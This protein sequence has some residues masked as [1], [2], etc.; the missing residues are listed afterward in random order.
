VWKQLKHKNIVPLLGATSDPLR[1]VSKWMPNGPLPDYLVRYPD[2][3]RLSLVCIP[4]V[5]FDSILTLTT[6]CL[7]SPRAL[8]I[9]TPAT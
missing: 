2:A 9:S 5:V 8:I 6:S 1:L 4:A 7:V 3:D